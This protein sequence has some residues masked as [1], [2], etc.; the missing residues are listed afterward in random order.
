MSFII[1]AVE[2]YATLGEISDTLR[3]VFG[4]QQEFR[5]TLE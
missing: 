2:V 4:E 5:G 3:R 1:D